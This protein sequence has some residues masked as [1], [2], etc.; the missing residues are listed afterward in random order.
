MQFTHSLPSSGRRRRT[1]RRIR[2]DHRRGVDRAGDRAVHAADRPANGRFET[3]IDACHR[4]PDGSRP[5]VELAAAFENASRGPRPRGSAAP[6]FTP[7]SRAIPWTDHA[8]RQRPVDANAAPSSSPPRCC[9]CSCSASWASPRL[10]PPVRREDRIADRHGQLR[11]GCGAGARPASPPRID[12]AQQRRHDGRQPEPGQHAVGHLGGQ[13]QI[14]DAD[15]TLQGCRLRR[16]PL[17]AA[18]A[19][20]RSASTPSRTCNCG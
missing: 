16:P 12:R 5:A 9:C 6:S 13:G 20:T 8:Q 11:P 14:V 3:F 1:S 17:P 2:A 10:R 15:I 4:L 7:S 19:R 18:A